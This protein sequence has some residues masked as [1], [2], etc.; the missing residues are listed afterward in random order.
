ME[1]LGRAFTF[2]FEDKAW[3]GKVILGGVFVLLSILLIGI[4]FVVGYILE[5]ARRSYEGN[6]IPLPE[7]DN[8]GEKFTQGLIFLVIIL[9]YAIPFI[10]FS[11]LRC[12]GPFFDF[13]YGI[14]FALAMPYLMMKFALTRDFNSAFQ[15]NEMIDFI[16]KNIGDII[17]VV[18]I[19]IGMQ[20]I[21]SFGVI[22]IVIGWFFTIFWAYLGE[23][24]LFGK[25]YRK[26]ET[27][28]VVETVEPG[29]SPQE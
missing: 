9:I 16:Q 17:I 3:P 24:Y 7:W 13:V 20:I 10:L 6:E 15:F 25:L 29:E 27:P 23:A 14:A 21:A 11:T 22:L 12:L 19:A 4:P 5:V 1:N 8:M 28:V 2:V 26:A 18:L